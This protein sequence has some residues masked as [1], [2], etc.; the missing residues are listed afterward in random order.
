M[1]GNL[2]ADTENSVREDC[3]LIS[4]PR[5]LHTFIVYILLWALYHLFLGFCR[6]LDHCKHF[7]TIRTDISSVLVAHTYDAWVIEHVWEYHTKNEITVGKMPG[8][9]AVARGLSLYIHLLA[10]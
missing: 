9:F 10:T 2:R 4:S 7:C 8:G 1:S 5:R 3:L 6:S